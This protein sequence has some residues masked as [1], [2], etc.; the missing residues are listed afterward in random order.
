MSKKR[1]IIV[2]SCMI[3]LLVA[4]ATLNFVLSGNSVYQDNL[5]STGYFAQYRSQL[6]S[7]RNEQLL[8]LDK[9][10]N[11]SEDDSTVKNEATTQKMQLLAITEQELRLESL[12][13]AYGY[14]EVVVTMS[15]NS[16]NVSV[17]VKEDSFEQSDAVKIYNLLA[18]ESN[19]DAEN[20]NIIPYL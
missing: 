12:I 14:D 4:T 5:T 7:Q 20:V 10:I 17:V 6:S 19:I 3:A 13:K 9:I 2:L 8:Q 15:V 11:E 16:P 1:K 18:S